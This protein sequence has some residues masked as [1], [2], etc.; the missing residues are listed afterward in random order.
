MFEST[1][2][3]RSKKP[4][5]G[6]KTR[7]GNGP[8]Q[9]RRTRRSSPP[10][11]K[12]DSPDHAGEGTKRRGGA[13]PTL[14]HGSAKP[15]PRGDDH[16]SASM[17]S[18]AVTPPVAPAPDKAAGASRGGPAPGLSM[19]QLEGEPKRSMRVRGNM[20]ELE[21]GMPPLD[22]TKRIKVRGR[23]ARA[24]VARGAQTPE[25]DDGETDAAGQV[26]LPGVAH[27]RLPNAGRAF[28]LPAR[29]VASAE[30]EWSVV[31][32][33]DVEYELDA[34]DDNWLGENT[35]MLNLDADRLEYLLDRLEKCKAKCS[36]DIEV[37]WE[38]LGSLVTTQVSTVTVAAVAGWWQEKRRRHP[39]PLLRRLRPQTD[40]HDQDPDR[41][42]RPQ[43]PAP[44]SVRERTSSVDYRVIAT[45]ANQ[46][47]TQPADP[48]KLDLAPN[49]RK[50]GQ[51]QASPA[52]A[53]RLPSSK[54]Q[55]RPGC[56]ITPPFLELTQPGPKWSDDSASVLDKIREMALAKVRQA[57]R[58]RAE[59]A[60]LKEGRN[61]P[62]TVQPQ[63]DAARK[64]SN[65]H[66]GRKQPRHL[67][68]LSSDGLNLVVGAT[69]AVKAAEF[70]EV[71]AKAEFGRKWRTA[72][73]TGV[74]VTVVSDAQFDGTDPRFQ[75]GAD[76]CMVKFEDGVFPVKPSM[77][78]V[79]ISP[80]QR[81]GSGY[82]L[83]QLANERQQQI[84]NA[85][86][87]IHTNS[88]RIS[89]GDSPGKRK[90][91][92]KNSDGQATKRHKSD[93]N[94]GANGDGDC[95]HARIFYAGDT[96][97][98]PKCM[99]L[100]KAPQAAY[101]LRC[102]GC[103]F[104]ITPA[105][106]RE[107]S[108]DAGDND[109]NDDT[110]GSAVSGD[111]NRESHELRCDS[112]NSA[113]DHFQPAAHRPPRPTMPMLSMLQQLQRQRAREASE[114]SLWP[115][116]S[117]TR[118][119]KVR[120]PHFKRWRVF[121]SVRM[122]AEAIG[123]D[124]SDVTKCAKGKLAQLQGWIC[125]YVREGETDAGGWLVPDELQADMKQAT[126]PV[127]PIRSIGDSG[128]EESE[129]ESEESEAESEESEAESEESEAEAV[130]S[131]DEE[132]AAAPDSEAEASEVE[133][134][135]A[136][137]SEA[138]ELA[139][140]SDSDDSE[141]D[142]GDATAEADIICMVCGLTD[143]DEKLVLCDGCDKAQ[144]TFCCKPKLKRVPKGEFRC[145]E[146]AAK[147]I[148]GRRRTTRSRP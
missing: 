14:V 143:H 75:D 85:M 33:P 38:Q 10:T 57:Q 107:R 142:D 71:H 116:K 146:C 20:V 131:E 102:A 88:G 55:I 97:R 72:T 110:D 113:E 12:P 61:Y 115:A 137:E 90:A 123:V 74:V 8:T 52:R 121:E 3:N 120:R 62:P 29:R 54:I 47:L 6:R 60:A 125:E 141:S 130:Q 67:P 56:C 16:D 43:M 79:L 105:S 100:M 138:E 128:R 66:A 139:A 24:R 1:R 135:G 78:T 109:G 35:E 124:R 134:S 119:V 96:V 99:E 44:M 91:A 36:D 133:E 84:R 30:K 2:V 73:Y 59:A 82:G 108:G 95:I 18:P 136:E 69:V 117:C 98:C 106:V 50:R 140:A 68:H 83:A 5:K 70:G 89:T 39:E 111:Q 13:C 46:P 42:F 94:Q 77:C 26:L 4:Q 51:R 63:R 21:G 148:R 27:S 17:D 25:L 19:L 129:S 28:K 80:E 11:T 65:A 104:A 45:G 127:A 53:Q 132:L 118:A 101:A 23:V 122:A 86:P 87:D 48:G 81:L 76:V 32:W 22:I 41:C 7:G 15:S 37:P 93:E 58:K 112:D 9:R 49:T 103:S 92:S 64:G 147:A 126:K 114:E 144:H 40:F 34:D 31:D 145:S